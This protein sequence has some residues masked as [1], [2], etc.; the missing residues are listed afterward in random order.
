MENKVR[1][2]ERESRM[3]S[4][5]RSRLGLKVHELPGKGVGLVGKGQAWLES[6]RA[7]GIWSE[8]RWVAEQKGVN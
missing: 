4:R 5:G 8:N 7:A 3:Q 1:K 6:S 2:T